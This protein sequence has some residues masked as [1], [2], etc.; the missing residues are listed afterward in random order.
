MDILD[1][2]GYELDRSGIIREPSDDAVPCTC[3]T[4]NISTHRWEI[5]VE[6][7]TSSAR[8]ATKRNLVRDHFSIWSRSGQSPATRSPENSRILESCRPI[9]TFVLVWKQGSGKQGF[10]DTVLSVAP[11]AL[12]KK[13]R[14]SAPSIDP[15]HRDHYIMNGGSKVLKCSTRHNCCTEDSRAGREKSCVASNSKAGTEL[16][17]GKFAFTVSTGVGLGLAVRDPWR[18]R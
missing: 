11:V 5:A 15:R 17:D 2:G 18:R 6:L 14:R 9:S 10:D 1:E 12:D 3:H 7:L 8:H 4:Q 16:R 13:F